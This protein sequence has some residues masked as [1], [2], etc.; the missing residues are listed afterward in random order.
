MDASHARGVQ[1][2]D[3]NAQHNYHVVVRRPDEVPVPAGRLVALPRLPVSPFVGRDGDLARLRQALSA[4]GTT[5]V[6][7]AVFG[8]GG[9]GKSELALQYATR[10]GES[11]GLVWWAAAEDGEVLQSSLAEL[12]RRLE[13]AHTQA[14]VTTGDAATWASQWL[15]AHPGWLLIL[16]NVEDQQTV[17]ALLAQVGPFGRVIITTRRDIN[18]RG[19]IRPLSLEVLEPDDAM[20]LLVGLTGRDGEHEA[21]AEL[22]AELGQLPLAL[23]QAG[24]YIGEQRI[25]ITGYLALLRARPV[26]AFAGVDQGGQ[27][28]RTIAR[29]WDITLDA[30]RERE[31][32]A[33][34]LLEVLSYLA[35]DGIPRRYLV[36]L[37]DEQARVDR[38]LGILASYSM[39]TL[40]D[41]TISVHRLVQ[42]VLRARCDD[43]TAVKDAARL[44]LEAMPSGNALTAVRAWPQWR[45]VIPHIDAFTLAVSD[46]HPSQSVAVLLANSAVFA[47]AQG[48]PEIALPKELRALRI[49]EAML[50][51]DHPRVA[52]GLDN[53][54]YTL[55]DLGRIEE[56]LPLQE[57]ALQISEAALGPDHTDVAVRLSNLGWTLSELNRVDEALPL[58]QRAF[59]ISEA[60]LGPDD[61]DVATW[62]DNLANTLSNMGRASEALPLQERALRISEA[63]LGPDHPSIATRLNNLAFTMVKLNRVG[64]AKRF[65]ER[66][67]RICETAL[68]PGHPRIA[69][70]KRNLEHLV[71]LLDPGSRDAVDL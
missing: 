2:G 6:G 3:N 70:V 37:T 4:T 51:A 61:P 46:D 50:G 22:V 30:I 1:V 14:G 65:Q 60:A 17:S 5:V 49:N 35:P 27:A 63:A 57:R 11:Y 24:A 69:E 28:S 26:E 38:A 15:Q 10:D 67:V 66:A 34:R 23:E 58:L 21:A 55:S 19:R 64:D 9:V 68:D 47:S 13:P 40:D 12:A 44:L 16:D 36:T 39:I 53:L 33:L 8:L 62:L 18:W 71:R 25:T 59:R 52:V 54:A 31:P 20:A 45:E 7:Q 32:F 48:Q 29:L 42:A 41:A 43:D 56:A